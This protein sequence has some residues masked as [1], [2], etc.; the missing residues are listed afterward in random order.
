MWLAV[1]LVCSVDISAGRARRPPPRQRPAALRSSAA[2]A[3]DA[4][5]IEY[6]S[7][8]VTTACPR[9]VTRTASPR[10]SGE[11]LVP[12]TSSP[13]A[14]HACSA[15]GRASAS[16]ISRSMK[17]GSRSRF[18]PPPPRGGGEKKKKMTSARPITA[19][20]VSGLDAYH[21]GA[22]HGQRAAS[23]FKRHHAS[24][25]DHD[26]CHR[27]DAAGACRLRA[28]GITIVPPEVR[29]LRPARSSMRT[30]VRIRRRRPLADGDLD[31]LRCSWWRVDVD[32]VADDLGVRSA[33]S[34]MVMF[35]V[36]GM[37]AP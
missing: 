3:P 13:T 26:R 4:A 2:V 32:L 9:Q 28:G 6:S 15:S 35:C 33:G 10:S 14:S 19:K 20:I 36:T 12:L 24:S 23:F 5:P 34:S 27:K 31:R 1:G 18:R 17:A 30:G 29:I 37:K 11:G 7:A 25:L 16:L 21:A 8:S 22:D